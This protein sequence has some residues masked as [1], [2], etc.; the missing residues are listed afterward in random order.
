MKKFYKMNYKIVFVSVLL[1]L[2]LSVN[3]FSAEEPELVIQNGHTGPV[4]SVNFSPDGKYLAS[5][6]GDKTIKIWEVKTGKLI[7]ILE[8]HT[9]IVESVNFS[10]DGK[11][12][13][14]GS[15]DETIKIWDVKT[16]KLIRTLEGHTKGVLSVNFSPD[17]KYLASGSWD[18]TIKLWNVETG[19]LLV[20]LLATKDGEW[21]TYTPEGYYDCSAGG[22]RFVAWR[23]GNE[24]FSFDQ[25][26]MVYKKPEIIQ[27][28]L[29]GKVKEIVA[30][31]FNYAPKINI[32][33]PEDGYITE[34]NQITMKIYATDVDDGVSSIKI[35][36]NG[37]LLEG[38]DLNFGK[39]VS[40]P[41]KDEVTE[42]FIIPLNAGENIIK[43]C[44][45]DISG[46]RSDYKT[47]RVEK[48]IIGRKLYLLSVG[49][50]K[51]KEPSVP[52]L[53]YARSDAETMVEL[54][55]KQEGILYE[56]VE[57][58]LLLDEQAT[59]ENIVN[60]RY[61]FLDNASAVDTIVIFFAGHG[62][63]DV[64]GNYYF[65]CYDAT[66]DKPAIRGLGYDEIKTKLISGLP[67]KQVL[68]LFD[69]CHS[70]AIGRGDVIAEEIR[71]ALEGFLKEGVIVISAATAMGYAIEKEGH[72]IFT[73]AIKEG[74]KNSK[75]DRNNDKKISAKELYFYIAS[76]TIKLSDKFQHPTGPNPDKVGLSDFVIYS[77]E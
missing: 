71:S 7:R 14:S 58:K 22:S 5:G 16:G 61:E 9:G 64:K 39:K 60:A 3:I 41:G 17:G 63:R 8:G 53:K 11:Y 2:C 25:Y 73:Y 15:E 29:A 26:E 35:E 24:V 62:V 45:F 34:D 12:L 20:T 42:S 77:V 31:P 50:N 55:K 48:K 49:I 13:A 1:T 18:T 4:S 28:L 56:K 65:L 74:L 66:F 75:A 32:S 67:S 57:T 44:A 23:V 68:L 33:Y 36:I 19:K 37:K 59:R 30:K 6:S 10:P 21:I 69:S 76:E 43:V 38:S 70:G 46:A 52:N 51:Y 47:I 54:F 27:Q 72:G 40:Q